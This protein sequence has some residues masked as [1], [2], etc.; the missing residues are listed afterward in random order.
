M[1]TSTI[2]VRPSVYAY[3]DSERWSRTMYSNP[4]AAIAAMS[5]QPSWRKPSPSN[6]PYSARCRTS[7][8][9]DRSMRRRNSTPNPLTSATAGSS[10]GSAYGA[11]N[12]IAMCTPRKMIPSIATGTQKSGEMSSLAPAS[13]AAAY[14][15]TST[16]AKIS[17][18]SSTLR[19]V[20][21]R[22]AATAPAPEVGDGAGITGAVTATV[23]RPQRYRWSDGLTRRCGGHRRGRAYRR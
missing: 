12:R 6:T 14:A 8:I 4:A 7:V 1:R 2:P 3:R 16:I 23:P 11:R 19:R 17:N 18:A 15:A 22:G 21:G 10:T 13:I 20:F 5:V 9:R